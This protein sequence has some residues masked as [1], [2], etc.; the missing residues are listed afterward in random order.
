[1]T[2]PYTFIDK[3]ERLSVV[4]E[5][6]E[7]Y[8]YDSNLGNT[9]AATILVKWANQLEHDENLRFLA[10]GGWD[11]RNGH[12]LAPSP[13]ERHRYFGGY[14]IH[15]VLD[16]DQIAHSSVETTPATQPSGVATRSDGTTVYATGNTLVVTPNGDFNNPL[17]QIENP[18]FARLHSVAFDADGRHVLTSASSLDMLYELDVENG[19]VVWSMDMWS[20]TPHN[21]NALGQHFFRS[22][23]SLE[24]NFLHN[25]TS[26]EL[27]DN[28]TLRGALCVVD[29]PETYKSLGLATALTPVFLNSVDYDYDQTLILATS[30]SMGEAWRIRRPTKTVE[31]VARGLGR[32][33][34]LHTAL[35]GYGYVLSDTLNEKVSIFNRDFSRERVIDL[36]GLG[37]RKVKLEKAKWLQYTTELRD[38]LFC[39]AMTSRQSLTLFDI[40]ART[41]RDIFVDP[42]WG[43]QMVVPRLSNLAP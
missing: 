32:P 31:V 14:I 20:D 7:S 4:S 15:T 13:R 23:D 36:S 17:R 22:G 28:E 26:F 1:M 39:A 25:P 6:I 30:F 16:Q 18:M 37:D 41:R 5:D 19:E 27:K 33:H 12:A 29:D 40:H 34:G 35:S 21:S 9:I 10:T 3:T 38:G 11:V 24:G 2:S 8:D 43:V 42:D